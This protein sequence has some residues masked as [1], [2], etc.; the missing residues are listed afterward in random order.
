MR[1][2]HAYPLSIAMSAIEGLASTT[3]ITTSLV[4]QVESVG[5]NALQLILVGTVLEMSVFA[6]EIPTGVLADVYSRR[7]SVVVG[8]ALTGAA[9]V[10]AGSIPAFAAVL[11]AQVVW[12]LGMTFGSGARTAWLADEIGAERLSHALV[13]NSQAGLVAGLAG[14]ALSVALASL[15]RS[16][17]LVVGGAMYLGLAAFAALAMTERGFTRPPAEER[18]TFRAMWRT[19]RQALHVIRGRRVLILIVM[20]PFLFGAASEV[21]D[22][23]TTPFLLQDL[24]IPPLGPLDPVAWFG[25]SN[26]VWLGLGFVTLEVIRRTVDTSNDRNVARALT[27]FQALY[28]GSLVVFGLATAFPLAIAMFWLRGPLRQA[29]DPLLSAWQNRFVPSRVR[30]TVLS[31]GGQMDAVGQVIG[32]PLLGAL[33]LGV[34]LRVGFVAAAIVLLPVV[35]AFAILGRSRAYTE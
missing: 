30:A 34:S 22:R 32:G 10:L 28:V 29:T 20:V 9:F 14:A 21:P 3:V 1:R 6:L 8:L 12:A 23:L 4:Y 13:R 24:A 25:L 35:I 31:F 15:D 16:W 7:L 18:E 11:A 27:A 2:L 19:T 5:L 33:A 17:P 26:Y